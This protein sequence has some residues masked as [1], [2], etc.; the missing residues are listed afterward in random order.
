MNTNVHLAE[1]YLEW[2]TF[3]T[4]DVQKIKTR[5]LCWIAFPKNRAFYKKM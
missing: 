3:Q 1:F 5:I 2:E 4:K